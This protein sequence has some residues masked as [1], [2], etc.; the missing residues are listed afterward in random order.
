M[1]V[2]QS[3]LPTPFSGHGPDTGTR[4]EQV[5]CRFDRLRTRS[6]GHSHALRASKVWSFKSEL[7][8]FGGLGE[9]QT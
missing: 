6:L 9:L 5:N 4:R 1:S 7:P 8:W 3:G 2:E